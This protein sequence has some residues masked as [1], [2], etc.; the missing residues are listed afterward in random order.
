MHSFQ[1][2]LYY[3]NELRITELYSNITLLSKLLF[4]PNKKN[5]DGS[6]YILNK[7]R[8]GRLFTFF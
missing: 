3:D 1:Y 2:S 6:G 5:M 4:W 8:V 7:I